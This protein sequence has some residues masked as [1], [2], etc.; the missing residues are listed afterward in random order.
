M[1]GKRVQPDLVREVNF[2]PTCPRRR[3]LPYGYHPMTVALFERVVSLA[4]AMAGGRGTRAAMADAAML[5]MASREW[6][7]LE[8][9][10]YKRGVPIPGPYEPAGSKGAVAREEVLHG[11]ALPVIGGL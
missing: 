5:R 2:D 11:K 1:A 8:K 6:D 9:L 7:R 3:R 10:A 4:M